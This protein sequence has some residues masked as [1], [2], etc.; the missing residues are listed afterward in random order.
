MKH[1]CCNV[2]FWY[3]LQRQASL[4]FVL[5][6]PKNCSV[7]KLTATLNRFNKCYEWN[8]RENFLFNS[9]SSSSVPS[10]SL[11]NVV[12]SLFTFFLRLLQPKAQHCVS[13]FPIFLTAYNNS[14]MAPIEFRGLHFLP[15]ATYEL[16]DPVLFLRSVSTLSSLVYRDS[17]GHGSASYD[18]QVRL[19]YHKQ[20]IVVI[21]QKTLK[22]TENYNY[23]EIN[24]PCSLGQTWLI[25][26]SWKIF[27]SATR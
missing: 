21:K 9:D 19:R 5:L 16:L 26:V 2:H 14:N 20:R 1:D 24:T 10:L 8:V 23:W 18:W 11:R 4:Y 17:L 6:R 13:N 22:T 25:Q 7:E 12:S 3:F 15:L 27:W